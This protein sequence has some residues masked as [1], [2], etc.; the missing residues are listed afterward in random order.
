MPDVVLASDDLAVL[1]GPATVKVE[2]DFGKEG[3]RGSR[4][5]SGPG[6]PST[7]TLGSVDLKLYDQYINVGPGDD[8]YGFM[9]QYIIVDGDTSPTWR[10]SLEIIGVVGPQGPVGPTGP[11]GVNINYAGSVNLVSELPTG[12]SINDAYI[13][14]EDGNLWVWNGF[15]WGDA[16]QIIGPAGPT[17]PEGPQGPQGLPGADGADGIDGTNGADGLGLPTGGLTG[18]VLVKASD[19]SGDFSWV[20][21]TSATDI[22]ASSIDGL[23]DVA[24]STPLNNQILT[25]EDSTSLWK[26]KALTGFVSQTN[27]TV[28][29]ASTSSSVVRNITLST[30]QPSGGNDGDV[31]LVYV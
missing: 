27:G 20:A 24:V 8:E 31:W 25:Y 29:T 28:T 22:T 10:K 5:Y 19:T 18:Q 7:T 12:A 2:V 4:I 23:Q 6:K 9:Y 21:K 26:N 3:I 13:V 15:V 14:N 17:G 16:G 11:Q 30:S 1:G